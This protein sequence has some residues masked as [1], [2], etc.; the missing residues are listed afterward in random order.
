MLLDDRV[1]V[2]G[3]CAININPTAEELAHIAISS[4]NTRKRVWN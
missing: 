3:D 4:A 2:Y 1:L